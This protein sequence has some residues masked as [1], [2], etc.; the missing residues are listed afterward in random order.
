MSSSCASSTAQMVCRLVRQRAAC[1]HRHGL[2][3][4]HEVEHELLIGE[5]LL[6]RDSVLG[7]LVEEGALHAL[8]PDR[9]PARGFGQERQRVTRPSQSGRLSQAMV[10]R[11]RMPRVVRLDEAHRLC[12]RGEQTTPARVVDRFL[13]YAYA[14]DDTAIEFYVPGEGGTLRRNVTAGFAAGAFLK[15]ND[16]PYDFLIESNTFVDGLG[17]A[18]WMLQMLFMGGVCGFSCLGSAAL[19]VITGVSSALTFGPLGG[20]VANRMVGGTAPYWKMVAYNPGD[21]RCLSG[22]PT[23]A[24]FVGR[25]RQVLRNCRDVLAAGGVLAL[26]IGDGRHEGRYLG[27]PFR[28]L[29]AA[30]AEGLWLAAP[31]IIR[32]GHGSTSARRA[33]SGSFIPRLHDVCLIL[34]RD[35]AAPQLW[36]A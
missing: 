30:A 1:A 9:P 13:G 25:L 23:V 19:P 4:D 18:A 10:V 28:A 3:G 6:A 2:D 15:V 29:D 35:P 16:K 14:Q 36:R 32:F 7:R 34:R 33:Y 17:F 20:L 12:P 8:V 24:A 31:E 22:P 26:L 5:R 11:R 21:A 27:L